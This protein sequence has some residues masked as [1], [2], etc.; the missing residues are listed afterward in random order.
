MSKCSVIR[1]EG[2]GGVGWK[3]KREGTHT[4][5][6]THTADSFCGRAETNTTLEN[7][8]PIK[9][10]KEIKNLNNNNQKNESKMKEEPSP[11]KH[12]CVD[13]LVK[14]HILCEYFKEKES[15]I[16]LRELEKKKEKKVTCLY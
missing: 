4:H 9:K 12:S 11:R 14:F 7:N 1:G 3:T 13:S 8:T 16:I 2:W 5:T 15:Y 6:H 10:K